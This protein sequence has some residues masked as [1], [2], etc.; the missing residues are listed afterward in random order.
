LGFVSEEQIVTIAII[1]SA[2]VAIVAIVAHATVIIHV[3]I[4]LFGHAIGFEAFAFIVAFEAF[5]AFTT[6][7]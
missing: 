6:S 3:A 5:E 4:A 7:G 2:I 1:E